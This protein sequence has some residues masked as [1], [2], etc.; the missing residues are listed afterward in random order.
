VKVFQDEMHQHMDTWSYEIQVLEFTLIVY[1]LEFIDEL[2]ESF[3]SCQ[4]V[5]FQF[6]ALM[7]H[8]CAKDKFAEMIVEFLRQEM[9]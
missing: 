2:E 8:V 9:I 4:E 7:D 3:V 1:D 6:V 5:F